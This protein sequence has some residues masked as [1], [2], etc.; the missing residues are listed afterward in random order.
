MDTIMATLKLLYPTL[1]ALL[2]GCVIILVLCL[3]ATSEACLSP[4]PSGNSSTNAN[5]Q[6]QSAQTGNTVQL[7][8]SP[9]ANDW[10]TSQRLDTHSPGP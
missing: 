5:T 4:S 10:P 9:N 6:T 2:T 1:A 3:L 7:H 8:P